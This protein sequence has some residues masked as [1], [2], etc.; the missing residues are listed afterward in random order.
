MDSMMPALRILLVEDSADDLALNLRALRDLDRPVLTECV[1]SEPA[2]REALARFLPDLVLCDFSMPGFSGQEA[3]RVVHEL[4]P[5]TPFIFV[6]GTIGEELAIDAL[7]RGAADYVLKDNL[8]RLRPAIERA[9]RTATERRDR[10]RIQ[11]ALSISEERFRAIVENTSDWIWEMDLG[12][13]LT[14]SNRSVADILGYPVEALYEHSALDFMLAEDRARVEAALPGL[15]ADKRGWKDWILRWRHRDGSVRLLESTAQPLFD[16]EGEVSVYRGIDRDVTLRVQQ[17]QKIR[18]LARIHAVLS[19]LGNAVLRAND[20]QELLDMTCQLTV[21]QGH[22]MAACIGERT[23]GGCLALSSHCGD[24]R[25]VRMIEALGDLPLGGPAQDARPAQRAFNEARNIAIAD[26]GALSI[27]EPIRQEMAQVGVASQIALPI[28]TPPWGVLGLFSDKPQEFDAEEISLL[29]RLTA[30]IDYA[31]KFIAKSEHL[32]YLAYH[33][34]TTGLPSRV[35]YRDLIVPRIERAPQAIAMADV[36]RFRYFNQSRGRPFGDQL[37]REIAARLKSLMPHGALLAH[38]SDDAFIF[39]FDH[40]GDLEAAM[41]KVDTILVAC[42]EQPFLVEGEQVRARLHG[43]VLL[44]PL[45]EDTADGIERTLVAV[46]AEAQTR[47]RA[48]LGFTEEV[49]SRATRRV[50]LERD[51]RHALENDGFELYLQ[52]KFHAATH[53]LTG[54]EALLRWRHP[55]RGMVSPAEFIPVLEETG[56]IV[57]AGA[58]V[59]RHALKVCQRWREL[60]S[61]GLRLAVNV[62]PRELR[63]LN[64]ITECEQLL[65]PFGGDH[66]LDIEIT[67][68]MLMDDIAH[69]IMVLQALRDLGCRVAIDDFGTGY[70]SLNYLSRLPADALKIDQSFVALLALSPDTLSLVTNIIGLAHSLGLKVVAEGVEEEEQAKLLRLL[71]CDEMQGYFFGRPV[72]QAQFEETWLH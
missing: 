3:L 26:Y 51:L 25:V 7:Q 52:P 23:P 48:V 64:F 12:K 1:A 59:R 29:E 56:L 18:Q 44:A 66:D 61:F 13:R 33:N 11:R 2:L 42:G 46:L 71:R 39:A 38:P 50:E 41:G 20:T 36:D 9:L 8:R 40:A 53:R 58:W 15:V 19:A 14:Y 72:P 35:A 30:E 10:L 68:S 63:Q 49:R 16:D 47:D 27:A 31:R 45:H 32:E 62:S 21:E 69:S 22:F 28:G 24:E 5:E 70:S 60:G 57:E 55:Q 4:T 67:E 43:S 37:L 54:A 65:A 6:S 17:E 34:P